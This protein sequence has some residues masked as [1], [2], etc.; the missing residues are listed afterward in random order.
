[1]KGSLLSVGRLETVLDA[2]GKLFSA[3][4]G[5]Q[6]NAPLTVFFH[7]LDWRL[8]RASGLSTPLSDGRCSAPLEISS[9]RLC[10]SAYKEYAYKG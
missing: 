2:F 5:D 9:R 7:A 4:K 3:S 8:P 10:V 6:F 1:M